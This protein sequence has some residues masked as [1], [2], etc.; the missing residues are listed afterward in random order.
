MK[1]IL[2]LFACGTVAT[3]A[4]IGLSQTVQGQ[5]AGDIT[6]VGSSYSSWSQTPSV[7]TG[8]TP[9]SGSGGSSQ[10]ND[11]WGG[12]A[13]G[14]AGFGALGQTF[15][16]TTPGTYILNSVQLEMAGAPAT[17][18]VELYDLGAYPAS[19]YPN[20]PQQI[21]SLGNGGSGGVNLLA[22]TYVA[23]TY[24]STYDQYSFS[25]TASTSLQT[26]TFGNLDANVT[27]RGGEL[28]M[29]SLDPTANADGTW[30]QRGGTESANAAYDT[31]MG[32]NE[33]GNYG[34]QGFEGKGGG[35]AGIRNFDLGVD[36][37]AVPEPCTIALGVF[38][39]S[40]LLLR[41]RK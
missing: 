20:T 19:G 26:L 35:T 25:G 23:G 18:N 29:L 7:D 8:P 15:E 6:A 37:T 12:N 5:A 30:W 16:I 36:V 3:I 34:M 11:N 40:S 28:Y 22:W 39:I 2:K 10:D 31:G 9:Q 32:Y 24:T 17:F 1:N 4:A 33:D 21:N 41:R 14:T 13:Y 38:G 27:L